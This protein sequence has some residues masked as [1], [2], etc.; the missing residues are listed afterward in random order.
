[1]AE[2]I[3]PDEEELRA[4]FIAAAGEEGLPRE[5]PLDKPF[6][7]RE[8]KMQRLKADNGVEIKCPAQLFQD[9]DAVSLENHSDGSFTI[10]FKHLRRLES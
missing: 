3:F 2:R 6:A 1:M 7:Q 9:P 5:L 4:E 8:F 10:T